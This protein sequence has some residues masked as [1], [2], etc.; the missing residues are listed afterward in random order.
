[1]NEQTKCVTEQVFRDHI[2]KSE[3][4]KVMIEKEIQKPL[5]M[6]NMYYVAWP[7]DKQSK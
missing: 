7:S 3:K 4:K 1:M 2:K 5:L 6:N